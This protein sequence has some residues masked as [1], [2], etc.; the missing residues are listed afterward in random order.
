MKLA[1]LKTLVGLR[2]QWQQQ[3]NQLRE[4]GERLVKVLSL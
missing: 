1:R 2:E 4:V 3:M